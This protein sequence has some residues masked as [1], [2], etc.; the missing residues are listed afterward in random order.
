[1]LP[2]GSGTV[3]DGSDRFGV[4]MNG[5]VAPAQT[6]PFLTAHYVVAHALHDPQMAARADEILRAMLSRQMRGEFQNGVVNEFNKGLDWTN[7]KGEA[8]GYEGYQELPAA[9]AARYY[10]PS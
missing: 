3:P 6:L 1:V 7:W 9:H 5:G 8:C 4:Y 2:W 10:S